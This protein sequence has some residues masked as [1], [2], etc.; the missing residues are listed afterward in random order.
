MNLNPLEYAMS[1]VGILGGELFRLFLAAELQDHQASGFIGKGAGKD[2]PPLSVERFQVGQMGRAVDLAFRLALRSVV[3]D[4]D[5]FHITGMFPF[6]G[7]MPVVF[8]DVVTV[9]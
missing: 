3:A 9:G 6:S 4:D 1:R 7:L 5:E 2:D 8:L